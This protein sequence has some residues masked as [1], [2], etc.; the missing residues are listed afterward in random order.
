MRV[1]QN[2][3]VEIFVGSK[4]EVDKT[5]EILQSDS[6]ECCYCQRSFE[7]KWQR[8]KHQ[9]ER[10]FD[11]R[12]RCLYC[13][14]VFYP[15]KNFK[16]HLEMAHQIAESVPTKEPRNEES[17]CSICGKYFKSL[18]E[19][20]LHETRVHIKKTDHKFKCAWCALTQVSAG[21]LRRHIRIKHKEHTINC[22][23][24]AAVCYTT[25]ELLSHK[26]VP[27]NICTTCNKSFPNQ[28]K[29]KKHHEF[30]LN[31]YQCTEDGCNATFAKPKS[32]NK[33]LKRH[34][35]QR[36]EIEV[37]QCQIC[38]HRFFDKS[39]LQVH[40]KKHHGV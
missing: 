25:E 31:E 23:A 21:E 18:R 29:L 12:W 32:L 24:C 39:H 26:C 2:N 7:A 8:V 4:E 19:V 37:E 34:K 1:N 6:I 30:C 33:H 20:K 22:D 13:R 11:T 9:Y 10:H 17:F 15:K 35:W 14:E 16:R 40:S 5:H 3:Q 27:E 36:G 28:T 38:G